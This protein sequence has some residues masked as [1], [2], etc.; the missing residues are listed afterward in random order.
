MLGVLLLAAGAAAETGPQARLECLGRVRRDL[1]QCMQRA[2]EACRSEFETH[3]PGCFPGSSCPTDCLRTE[4]SCL[5]EPLADRDGCRLAC[6]ADQ[7]VGLKGCK[8]AAEPGDCRRTV[9]MKG[10]KC[11]TNCARMVESALQGCKAAFDDCI[12][13]C[14]SGAQ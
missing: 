3:L 1:G 9:R 11:K 7:K 13:G 5:A 4:E 12:R 8:I 6:Q 14:A 10:S 2:R